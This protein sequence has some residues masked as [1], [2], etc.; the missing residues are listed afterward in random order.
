MQDA[1][2]NCEESGDLYYITAAI[3]KLTGDIENCKMYMNEAIRNYQTLTVPV[4][5]VKEEL[6]R[7]R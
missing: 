5:I 1:L 4:N 7:I 3:Y 2:S 6:N